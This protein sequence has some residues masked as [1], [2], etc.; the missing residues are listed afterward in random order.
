MHTTSIPI[1]CGFSYSMFPTASST[2]NAP[3][4]MFSVSLPDKTVL[5][6]IASLTNNAP[7]LSSI[8]CWSFSVSLDHP[9]FAYCNA[10]RLWSHLYHLS[11]AVRSASPKRKL[12]SSGK[13]RKLHLTEQQRLWKPPI[14]GSTTTYRTHSNIQGM[15]S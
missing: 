7:S 5:F 3:S 4:S 9:H 2:S 11:L 12:A 8:T 10:C 6:S 15:N 14:F 13:W 1:F